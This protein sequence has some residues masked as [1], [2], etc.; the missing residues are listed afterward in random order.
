M[1][2]RQSVERVAAGKTGLEFVPVAQRGFAEEVAE[3]DH[4][5]F[6]FVVEVDEP[7]GHVLNFDPPTVERGRRLPHL[8]VEGLHAPLAA[9][10]PGVH[11]QV[12][13]A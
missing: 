8:P 5:P 4:A 13:I 12:A 6:A 11:Q 3:E 9:I 10:L 2:P 7:A 1:L